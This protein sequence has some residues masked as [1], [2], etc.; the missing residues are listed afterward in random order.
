MCPTCSCQESW[1]SRI[2]AITSEVAPTRISPTPAAVG[3][4]I[5]GDTPN[6]PPDPGAYLKPIEDALRAPITFGNLEGTLTTAS[7]SKCGSGSSQ[8][9]AFRNPPSYGGVLAGAGFDVMNSA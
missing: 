3:D 2:W 4:T 6:L 9:F 8:C 5:L 7:R 1:A